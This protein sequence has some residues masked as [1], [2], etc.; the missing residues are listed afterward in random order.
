MNESQMI[1]PTVAPGSEKPTRI[2]TFLPMEAGTSGSVDIWETENGTRNYSV[3]LDTEVIHPDQYLQ[4]IHALYN[5]RNGD[6]MTI[7]IN[8]NGGWVETGIDIVTAMANTRGHVETIALG[9]CA[10]IAA[11]IWSCG[12][13]R[14][15]S[16]LATIM[17]HMPSGGYFGKSLDIQAETEGLNDYFKR[18]LADITKGLL[19]SE[20]IINIV[21]NRMDIYISGP[22]MEERMRAYEERKKKDMAESTSAEEGATE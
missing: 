4:L 15:V 16:P 20:D 2:A 18:L 8:S 1:P 6:K 13:T 5:M 17:Y 10:S 19:T 11:V 22:V 3:M 7:I 14:K 21:D 12:H 9:M